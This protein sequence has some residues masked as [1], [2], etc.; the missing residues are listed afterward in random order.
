[1]ASLS[2]DF[3]RP[4]GAFLYNMTQPRAT[5]DGHDVPVPGWGQH[6]FDVVAGGPHRIDIYVPY[7]LPRKAGRATIDVVVPEGGVALEYMAPTVAY[8]KGSLGPAGQ[9]KSSGFKMVHAFNAAAVLLAVGY[10][11]FKSLA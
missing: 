1:M 5:V 8:A 11:L 4:T 7:A 6:F 3:R 2:I 10:F 9:Q